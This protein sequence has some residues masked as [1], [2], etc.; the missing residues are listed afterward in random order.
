M[1]RIVHVLL[2]LSLVCCSLAP[3]QGKGKGKGKGN[4]HGEAA[5]EPSQGMG[6]RFQP[7][8]T[9]IITGYYG[10]D[11]SNLPPGLAKRGGN[12]PPGLQKQ[13]QRNGQLPPGLQKRLEPFP[14]VLERRLPPLP[15]GCR[16][17]VVGSQALL[18]DDASNVVLDIVDLPRRR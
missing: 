11:T 8:E 6:R 15:R 12:L 7:Q 13:L 9:Q 5:L 2:L 18:I 17:V 1:R 3:G 16:R 10:S 4:K 14:V